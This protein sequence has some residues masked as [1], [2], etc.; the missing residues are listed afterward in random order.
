[1]YYTAKVRVFGD[2][3]SKSG[4]KSVMCRNRAFIIEDVETGDTWD[5]T[6]VAKND[7]GTSLA[8]RS[9]LRIGKTAIGFLSVYA[10]PDELIQDGDDDEHYR[11]L[12]KWIKENPER[13]EELGYTRKERNDATE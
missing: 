10:T 11:R 13:A 3:Q 4:Q 8:T 2:N 7:K 12:R 6:L 1:M 9:S 5:V